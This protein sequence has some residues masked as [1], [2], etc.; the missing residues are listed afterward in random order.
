MNLYSIYDKVNNQF[1]F[2]SNTIVAHEGVGIILKSLT[3]E[4]DIALVETEPFILQKVLTS[5]IT[6]RK[7]LPNLMEV[8]EQVTLGSPTLAGKKPKTANVKI[9][10]EYLGSD[11]VLNHIKSGKMVHSIGLELDGGLFFEI[12]HKFNISKITYENHLDHEDNSELS[13]EDNFVLEY[14]LK[15]AE[16]SK[17]LNILYTEVVANTPLEEKE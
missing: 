16:I 9:V 14:T 11:E 5:Y 6:D 8:D 4:I 1:L 13:V 10:K 2:D 17:V 12:D 15:L 3:H 7:M